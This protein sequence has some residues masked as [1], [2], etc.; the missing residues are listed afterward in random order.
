[1]TEKRAKLA[2]TCQKKMTVSTALVGNNLSTAQR[3]L[4]KPER[5]VEKI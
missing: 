5:N 3:H 4:I 2:E 1:M